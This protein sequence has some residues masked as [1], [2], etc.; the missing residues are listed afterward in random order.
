MEIAKLLRLEYEVKYSSIGKC[1]HCNEEIKTKES[2][3]LLDNL[4]D[5]YIAGAVYHNCLLNI[6]NI[7]ETWFEKL[8]EKIPVISETQCVTICV[9]EGICPNCHEDITIKKWIACD[10][11][12]P[13]APEPGYYKEIHGLER[14][15]ACNDFIHISS[16]NFY[17]GDECPD[18]IAI[19]QDSIDAIRDITEL[20][21]EERRIKRGRPH[22]KDIK[23]FPC[24]VC[25]GK[26]KV[27][28]SLYGTNTTSDTADVQCRSCQGL[29]YVGT[30]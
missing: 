2:E 13:P 16:G 15:P 20:Q 11:N 28:A 26:Q 23:M 8:K 17:N 24:P 25:K 14:C 4:G 22:K 5:K 1:P 18:H 3:V 7:R 21:N 27:S 30:K 9:L 29:G 6:E 19:S 12:H 10:F